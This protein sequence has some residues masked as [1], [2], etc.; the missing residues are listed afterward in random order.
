[1]RTVRLSLTGVVALALVGGLGGAVVAQNAESEI[2]AAAEQGVVFSTGTSS[3]VDYVDVGVE[4]TG[5]DGIARYRGLIASTVHEST[6]PR[7][8]G[9]ATL[10]W[11]RDAY[12]GYDG[13]EW[14]TIRS[15]NDEG[16]WQG[17]YSAFMFPDDEVEWYVAYIMVSEG[18]GG[19]EGLVSVCQSL[20]PGGGWDAQTKCVVMPGDLSDFGE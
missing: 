20:V 13:P 14:G 2:L 10:V 12:A 9:P 4:E 5:E 18:E 8:S 1:M 16:A 15:E 6:D 17:T 19:Y 11:N 3:L 7:L